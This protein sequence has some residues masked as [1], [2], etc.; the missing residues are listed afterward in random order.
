M[1]IFLGAVLIYNGKK[2]DCELGVKNMFLL[3][4]SYMGFI[5]I[6]ILF[7][8]ITFYDKF[9]YNSGRILILYLSYEIIEFGICAYSLGNYVSVGKNNCI[10]IAPRLFWPAW[11]YTYFCYYIILK[12]AAIIFVVLMILLVV[13]F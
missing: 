12:G 5:R 9:K 3:Q 2:R 6:P 4:I 11:I 8:I 13:C 10:H 7:Q 1:V